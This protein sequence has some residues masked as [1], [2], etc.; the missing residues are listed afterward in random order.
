MI[1]G[2]LTVELAVPDAG[3]LKDKRRVVQSLKRRLRNGFN[4]SVA[5]VAYNDQP[6]RCRLAIALVCSEARPVHAQLDKT[7]DL[8]RG[9]RGVTLLDYERE[10]L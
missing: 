4:V 3:S 10:L 9:T 8:I 5:E 1:V 2:V 7:V 6:R